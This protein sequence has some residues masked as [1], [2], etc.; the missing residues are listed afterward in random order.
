MTTNVSKD[1]IASDDHVVNLQ[2]LILTDVDWRSIHSA[3]MSIRILNHLFTARIVTKMAQ[4]PNIDHELTSNVEIAMSLSKMAQEL[5]D[6][7]L[8]YG[9]HKLAAAEMICKQNFQEANDVFVL[10]VKPTD[11]PSIT[12]RNKLEI[13]YANI[14]NSEI[15]EFM[16]AG[17]SN[18]DSFDFEDTRKK[19]AQSSWET[20][21]TVKSAASKL[22]RNQKLAKYVK[23]FESLA[24]K[25]TATTRTATETLKK[26]LTSV[27]LLVHA[28][29]APVLSHDIGN[30][31]TVTP[32]RSQ[33]AT[34]FSQNTTVNN[35]STFSGSLLSKQ[36]HVAIISYEMVDPSSLVLISSLFEKSISLYS[37]VCKNLIPPECAVTDVHAL[38][39][40]KELLNVKYDACEITSQSI[41]FVSLF[42]KLHPQVCHSLDNAHKFLMTKS[43]QVAF[44]SET[45]QPGQLLAHTMVS[46]ARF[47]RDYLLNGWPEMKTKRHTATA[48]GANIDGTGNG[49]NPTRLQYECTVKYLASCL[50]MLIR[51]G[52]DAL[53]APLAVFEWVVPTVV[54][55]QEQYLPPSATK[56]KKLHVPQTA[57]P[58]QPE[59]THQSLMLSELNTSKGSLIPGSPVRG[60]T[61]L[62][63]LTHLGSSSGIGRGVDTRD[64]SFAANSKMNTSTSTLG[65]LRSLQIE[66]EK[67]PDPVLTIVGGGALCGEA[68]ICYLG[69]KFEL[70]QAIQFCVDVSIHT[71]IDHETAASITGD[72][73]NDAVVFH[74]LKQCRQFISDRI[75][76]AITNGKQN[77][78]ECIEVCSKYRLGI[79]VTFTY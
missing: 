46:L 42:I 9:F 58:F 59:S 57:T 66:A 22:I 78:K 74:L 41:S 52:M 4:N 11:A 62:G 75:L 63:A 28:T 49:N 19:K 7:I 61:S 10:S 12:V 53:A 27:S 5:F 38:L 33:F 32:S 51:V 73:S 64:G 31:P 25:L 1:L 20:L 70:L 23:A 13:E 24:T 36:Q 17:N 79:F 6:G 67:T 50:M 54:Q 40:T 15:D 39:G 18:N 29:I 77:D 26:I 55:K 60:G 37:M 45:E 44:D 16:N 71:R 35:A 8:S 48:A 21:L 43:E 47:S 76:H 68:A 65:Y 3:S 14:V 34:D 2:D 72:H 56:R 30:N 69:K